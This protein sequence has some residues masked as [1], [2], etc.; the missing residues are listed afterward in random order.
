MKDGRASNGDTAKGPDYTCAERRRELKLSRKL[1]IT[2]SICLV[3]QASRTRMENHR[4]DR[5][6]LPAFYSFIFP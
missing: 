6:G 3:G 5:I 4:C 2:A 1:P